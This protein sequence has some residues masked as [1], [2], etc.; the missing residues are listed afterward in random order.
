MFKHPSTFYIPV[1]VVVVVVVILVLSYGV[2]SETT[3]FVLGLP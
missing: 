3:E 1:F 2:P